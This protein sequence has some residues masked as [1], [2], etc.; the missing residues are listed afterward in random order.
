M[1]IGRQRRRDQIVGTVAA[2]R[3]GTGDDEVA[4]RQLDDSSLELMYVFQDGEEG[5]PGT[6]PVRVI[7]RVTDENALRME[8]S[9]AAIDKETV[10]NFT[11]HTW[12]IIVSHNN[13]FTF[14]FNI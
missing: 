10:A 3:L 9:A 8:W 6:L 5:Y 12:Y 4:A 2:Q 14:W 1:C 7:Y 13:H 11:N